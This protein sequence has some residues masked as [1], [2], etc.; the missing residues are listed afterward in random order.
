MAFVPEKG[1]VMKTARFE[2]LALVPSCSSAALA[3]ADSATRELHA[4]FTESWE[5]E[6]R[7][8]PLRATSAG[9]RH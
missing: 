1:F 5:Q 9:D 8:N 2:A 4:P 7:D 3:T 6:L